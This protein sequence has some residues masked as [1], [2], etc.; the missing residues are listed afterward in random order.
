MNRS[1]AC[2]QKMGLI[3]LTIMTASNMMGSGVFM[4]PATLAQLGAVSLWGWGITFLGVLALALLFCKMNAISPRNGGIIANIHAVFGPFIGLEMTLFYWLSTWVG[5][6]AL[7]LAGIG[8]LAFFLPILRQPPFGALA[9]IALL[10]L[11]VLLGLGGARRVGRAQLLT[12]GCML[13]VILSLGLFGWRHFD[14]TRYFAAWNV[15]G[16]PDRR[17]IIHASLLSLWGFLG[18]ESASVSYSQVQKPQRTVPLAT[19]AGLAIAGLCYA[20]SSSVIMGILPHAQLVSSSSPFADSASRI[21]GEQSGAVVSAL[22]IVACLGAI[23]GWQILQTEVPRAAAENGLFPSVFA[24]TNR[25]GVP[26]IALLFT[27][28][29]M[30]LFLLGTLS[31]DIQ[32]QFRTVITLAVS[33]GLFPYAFAAL[34]LPVILF[35]QPRRSR[36]SLLGYSLLSAAALLFIAMALLFSHTHALLW[37]VLLMAATSPLYGLYRLRRQRR[38]ASRTSSPPLSASPWTSNK[39]S[40]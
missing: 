5:N 18:I 10:W 31:P 37:A 32:S 22:V 26:W 38:A 24:R 16:L 19:L 4:L 40:S 2:A 14:A 12:G 28:A 21:W 1:P 33:A 13:A 30:T 15:S 23:P 3:A 6:C 7:L 39:E 35:R 25:F 34:A 36:W 8:Y 17:A 9:C 29:L 27:T 20:S 11:S